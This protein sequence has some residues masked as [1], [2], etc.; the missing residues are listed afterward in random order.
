[1]LP[2]YADEFADKFEEME[3][4]GKDAPQKGCVFSCKGTPK[5]RGLCASSTLTVPP[6]ARNFSATGC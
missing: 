6:S 4:N 2:E 3:D 1:M 5:A